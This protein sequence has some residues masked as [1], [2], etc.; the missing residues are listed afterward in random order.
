VP[1]PAHPPVHPATVAPVAATSRLKHEASAVRLTPQRRFLLLRY[2]MIAITAVLLLAEHDLHLPPFAAL[3]L[4]ML[5]FASNV[6]IA[7]WPN[8]FTASASFAPAIIVADTAWMTMALIISG[9][10]DAEF[11]FAFFF[12]MLLAAI[13]ERLWL[14]GV[15]AAAACGAYVYVLPASG[16]E[17]SLW[18]SPSLIRLPFL[19]TAAVYYGYL[20]D[21]ARVA[22]R[23]AQE[24]DRIKSEFLGTISHELRTPLTVILGYVDLLLEDEFGPLSSEQRPI[25]DKVRAAGGNLHRYLSRLL[26]VSRLVN[27]LQSG[28]ESIVCGEFTLASVFSEL[29]YDF[30]DLTGAR[31]EWPAVADLPRLYTDREKLVTILRNLIE[32]ALKYSNGSPAT[33]GAAHGDSGDTV[34]LTVADRG[35]GIGAEEL[36]HVFDPFRRTEQAVA[37]QT[38]GVGLG[39]YIVKQFTELLDGTIEVESA[40]GIG[41]TFTV[42]IPRQLRRPPRPSSA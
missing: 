7:A 29:R 34:V 3:L 16:G 41:S 19:F 28:G 14:I 15:A 24:A 40:P 30:L 13:G 18:S 25:V 21:R 36:P 39:L 11:F 9:R 10:F 31:V 22:R 42:R 23:R 20:A 4:V 1:R 2:A 12:V 35:I 37:T 38:Q 6:L 8:R 33:I 27:R 32:N 26:D 5:A 17:W